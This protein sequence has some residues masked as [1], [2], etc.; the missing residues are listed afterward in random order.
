MS[1]DTNSICRACGVFEP[2]HGL[3]AT[4]MDFYHTVEEFDAELMKRWGMKPADLPPDHQN[5]RIRAFLEKHQ[6]HGE[7]EYWSWD[8]IY[9]E[10]DP[11]KDLT[12]V[13]GVS[14]LD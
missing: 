3:N 13:G 1:R 6:G 8:W 9:D 12:P 5:A 4:L 11:L 10:D 2:G 7:V 14:Y